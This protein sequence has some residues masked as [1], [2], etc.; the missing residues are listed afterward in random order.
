[1]TSINR[2]VDHLVDRSVATATTNYHDQVRW[3][4]IIAGLVTA[5]STQLVLSALG[6]AIGASSISGSGAPRSEAGGVGVNIG[7]W[8]IVS[9]LISLFTGGWVAARSAGRMS[10]NTALLNGAIL[11]ASTLALSAWLV[12]SGV[13]GAF[14]IAASNASTLI[15]QVQQSPTAPA[16]GVTAQQARDL[17]DNAA[18]VSWSFVFGSLLGLVSALAGSAAGCRTPRSVLNDGYAAPIGSRD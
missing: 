3:G 18:K 1:M 8:S 9:L 7:I 14:G 5:L 11:W 16:V 6:V 2:P 15:N 13:T 4:P 12:S 17:A 10:R